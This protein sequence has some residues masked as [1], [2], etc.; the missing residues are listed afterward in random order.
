MYTEVAGR[1]SDKKV[2]GAPVSEIR[3]VLFEKV[4][5]WHLDHIPG[6]SLQDCKERSTT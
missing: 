3:K 6:I 2:R 1:F 4:E 5:V